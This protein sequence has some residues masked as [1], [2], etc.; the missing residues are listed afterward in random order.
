M[1]T[2]QEQEVA[3]SGGRSVVIAIDDTSECERAVA[4]SV[5]NFVR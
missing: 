2:I 3:P 4:W 5:D 1:N